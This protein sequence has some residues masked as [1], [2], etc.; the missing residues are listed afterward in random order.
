[1]KNSSKIKVITCFSVLG[2]VDISKKIQFSL[3]LS[4]GFVYV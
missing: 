1:M 4:V 3:Y 2:Q